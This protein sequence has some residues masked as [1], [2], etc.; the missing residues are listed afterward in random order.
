VLRDNLT[1]IMY[2]SLGLYQY[3]I[4]ELRTRVDI[5]KVIGKYTGLG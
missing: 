2:K 1:N 5:T 4:S 3:V